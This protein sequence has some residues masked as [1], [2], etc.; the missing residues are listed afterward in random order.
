MYEKRLI[1]KLTHNVQKYLYGS[2]CTYFT[3]IQVRLVGIVT[4]TILKF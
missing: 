3:G 2:L 4:T 1:E